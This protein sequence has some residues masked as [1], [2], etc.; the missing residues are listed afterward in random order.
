M[1]IAE[2]LQKFQIELKGTKA[3]LIAVSKTKPN[4]TI[5]E[6]YNIGWKRF[7]ENKV[8]ELVSKHD[9]LPKDIEWHLIGTLQSNK[10]KYIAPFVYLIHAVDKE[11]LLKEINKRAEQNDRIIN[12]LLQIHIAD[13]DTKFGF[14]YEEAENLLQNNIEQYKNV[15][16]LGLMGMATNTDNHTQVRQEFKALK[17]FFDKIKS[18]LNTENIDFQELSMGMSGDYKIAIEEGSTMIRVGSAIFGARNYQ[19]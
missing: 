3:K 19:K 1:K 17:T 15:K 14:T 9:A 13:E 2:N 5:L 12:C 4:E 10:V 6:A 8:Q 7:G 16:I 11:K 18:E